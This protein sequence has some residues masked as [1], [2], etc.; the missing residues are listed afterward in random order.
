MTGIF[1]A[2]LEQPK[3]AYKAG[4][5]PL[6][7]KWQSLI[8]L[9]DTCSKKY[10][11]GPFIQMKCNPGADCMHDVSVQWRATVAESKKCLVG[12]CLGCDGKE[13]A[14]GSGKTCGH[15]ADT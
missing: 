11:E 8:N 14:E 2:H 15:I 13:P 6:E 3:G 9:A 12:L 10:H 4:R 7:A 1:Y 5:N